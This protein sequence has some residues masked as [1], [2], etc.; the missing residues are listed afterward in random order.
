MAVPLLSACEIMQQ[1]SCRRRGVLWDGRKVKTFR[2]P[3]AAPSG[4]GEPAGIW[5]TCGSLGG[6][7]SRP[8]LNDHTP[9][10][11]KGLLFN[12]YNWPDRFTS[13]QEL[14]F[15]FDCCNDCYSIRVAVDWLATT[16]QSVWFSIVPR[17]STS[18]DELTKSH[19]VDLLSDR[20]CRLNLQLSQ[21]I[22]KR[23]LKKKK[24]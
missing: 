2:G 24:K 4:P 16:L 21:C 19:F 15:F 17:R 23:N 18:E 20:S 5:L 7:N 22:K 14:T 13:C 6:H 9:L 1:M 3:S 8:C 10:S 12:P 11:I